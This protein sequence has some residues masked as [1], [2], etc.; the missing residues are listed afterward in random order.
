[1]RFQ[2]KTL[3]LKSGISPVA[4]S[5]FE[6]RN[7]YVCQQAA[8][9]GNHEDILAYFCQPNSVRKFAWSSLEDPD[10]YYV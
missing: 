6:V 10:N 7:S 8:V 9:C 5:N 1:M 4:N 2:T 3:Q